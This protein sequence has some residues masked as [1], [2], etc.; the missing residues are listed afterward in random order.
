MTPE[1]QKFIS[2]KANT[3]DRV[4]SGELTVRMANTLIQPELD[5]CIHASYLTKQDF[6][7]EVLTNQ[8]PPNVS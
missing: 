7:K 1:V 2:F 5:R 3:L 4:S 8:Y 6:I